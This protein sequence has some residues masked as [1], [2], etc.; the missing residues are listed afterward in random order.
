LELCQPFRKEKWQ[1]TTNEKPGLFFKARGQTIL[2]ERKEMKKNG[3]KKGQ[4][5]QI[6]GRNTSRRRGTATRWIKRDLS[7]KRGKVNP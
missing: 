5:D 3:K 7:S 4:Q 2:I 1:N 6:K